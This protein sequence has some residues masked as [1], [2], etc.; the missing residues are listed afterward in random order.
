MISAQEFAKN[1][2]PHAVPAELVKLLAFQ[3][4]VGKFGRYAKGFGLE[5]DDKSG[6][7]SWSE[8]PEFLARL[9]PFARARGTGSFYA[10]WADG[11]AT[12]DGTTTDSSSLPVV[13]CGDEG[14]IH[15]V[16]ENVRGL[17]SLLCFDI[18]PTIDLDGVDFYKDE[19]DHK[20]SENH[21]KYLEWFSKLG[22]EPVEDP[23][24]IVTAAQARYQARFAAWLA[25]YYDAD[26]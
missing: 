24:T 19:D 14:G 8:D 18:E 20:A 9:L 21:Q 12:A 26:A 5:R 2:A 11:D 25:R 3:E 1:F 13:A 15:V 7:K 6:L 23:E 17:L 4:D 10:L 22:L 16:A